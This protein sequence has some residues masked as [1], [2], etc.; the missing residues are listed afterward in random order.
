MMVGEDV[1]E[2]LTDRLSSATQCKEASMGRIMGAEKWVMYTIF[3]L[4]SWLAL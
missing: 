1:W 3:F 4:A 2:Y